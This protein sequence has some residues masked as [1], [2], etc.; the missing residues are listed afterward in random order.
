MQI[1]SLRRQLFCAFLLFLPPGVNA[2]HSFVRLAMIVS[3]KERILSALSLFVAGILMFSAGAFNS[4]NAFSAAI[5]AQAN[6]T[7]VEIDMISSAGGLGFTVAPV[8]GVLVDKF[9]QKYTLLVA[10]FCNGLGYGV[11]LGVMARVLPPSFPL[12][13]GAL[14]FCAAGTMFTYMTS[15]LTVTRNIPQ[16]YRGMAVSVALVLFSGSASVFA[17]MYGLHFGVP[18]AQPEQQDVFGML[19]IMATIAMLGD[20][21]GIVFLRFTSVLPC[22]LMESSS[23]AS[24]FE[25]ALA[26]YGA[27]SSELQADDEDDSEEVDT[28]GARDQ[29]T[30][31]RGSA[32]ALDSPRPRE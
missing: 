22:R 4:H 5:K 10:M 2:I 6:F 28:R 14:L 15:L 21:L 23:S 16:A 8:A 27:Y 19:V 7:Q 13:F 17:A 11:S 12:L 9:A 18:I 29:E 20:A 30:A 31:L 25:V 32:V 26:E 3:T 1:I 24:R